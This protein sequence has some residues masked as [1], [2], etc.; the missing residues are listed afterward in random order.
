MWALIWVISL[1]VD[2]AKATLSPTEITHGWEHQH[3]KSNTDI[4]PVIFSMDFTK[5]I[6]A[7]LESGSF[8]FCVTKG[9]VTKNR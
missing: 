9:T 2:S 8:S 3:F 1:Y 5:A 6:K 4:T 7:H